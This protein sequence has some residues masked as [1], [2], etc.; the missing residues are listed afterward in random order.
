MK[1]NKE[2][3]EEKFAM[4]SRWEQSGLSQRQFC[5]TENL[6]FNHFYYWL[7][8]YRGKNS[9]KPTGFIKLISEDKP[10]STRH[11][12]SEVILAN[13]NTIRFY[14]SVDGSVLK[15]LAG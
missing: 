15:Q 11:I 7:K 1:N 14:Q 12:F 9:N 5:Q 2:L 4:I 3:R 13:G 10:V 6:Q 8:R